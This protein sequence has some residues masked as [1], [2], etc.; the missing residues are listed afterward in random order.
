MNTPD[1]SQNSE[2]SFR[3]DEKYLCQLPA[4][5]VLVDLGYQH[6]TPAEALAARGGK[7][8]NVLLKTRK[9]DLM[10]KLLT[11]R[12]RLSLPETEPAKKDAA[13]C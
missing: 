11:G 2:P 7:A 10:Q 4:L 3:F 1:T 6:L 8:G 5:Q 12:S 9:R 13:P